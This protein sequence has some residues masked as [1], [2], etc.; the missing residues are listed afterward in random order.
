MATPP[1]PSCRKCNGVGFVA[2]RLGLGQ[3]DYRQCDCREDPLAEDRRRRLYA[4]L[5]NPGSPKTFSNFIESDKNREALEASLAF[6][7]RRTLAH[8]LNLYGPHGGG[9]SHLLEAIGR[10]MLA[11]KRWVKYAFAPDLLDALRSSY[12]P[13]SEDRFAVVYERYSLPDVLLL[14][15]LGAEKSS[16]WAV[17]KLTRLVDERYRAG[18]LMVV[19]ANLSEEAMADKLA[20]RIADRL[21]DRRTGAVKVVC[22][23][24]DSHRTGRRWKMSWPVRRG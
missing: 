20:P 15:D 3:F 9:K 19:A 24:D 11:Q 12:S 21:F 10:E 16:E 8:V 14:D 22:L 1:L 18:K 6:A 17:E 2:Y 23:D 4:D 7:H 5:P 13:E